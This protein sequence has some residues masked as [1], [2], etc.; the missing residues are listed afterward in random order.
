MTLSPPPA[1]LLGIYT[2]YTT[3]E[4]C[5]K[6]II[7]A[8]LLREKTG[9]T[10]IALSMGPLKAEKVLKDAF[11]LSADRCILL[12]DRKFGGSDT[13]STSYILSEAVKKIGNIDLPKK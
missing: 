12:S 9:G 3:R 1:S 13:W 10:V 6:H 2:K 8:L 5:L 4:T 11:A 7:Q